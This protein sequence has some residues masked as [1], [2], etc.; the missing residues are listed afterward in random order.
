MVIHLEHTTAA[1]RTVVGTIGFLGLALVAESH[2][3]VGSF[4]CERGVLH[5]APFLRR[6]MTIAIVEVERRARI[7]KY[8]GRVTPVE[9]EIE[10]DAE[11]RGELS[12]CGCQL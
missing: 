4:D 11:R 12:W 1:C 5:L 6:Q 7:G 10:E 2:T 9:H 8:G 3:S